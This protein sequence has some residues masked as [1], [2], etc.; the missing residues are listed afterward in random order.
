MSF[1]TIT[2]DRER[3][4]VACLRQNIIDEYEKKSEELLDYLNV[5]EVELDL[6]QHEFE[7]REAFLRHENNLLKNK[8]NQRL[9]WSK[10]EES[11]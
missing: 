11:I 10:P 8:L 3:Y 4:E 9:K 5:M 1:K 2:L 7:Q 6:Q